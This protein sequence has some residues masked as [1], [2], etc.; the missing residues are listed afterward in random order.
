MKQGELPR[1]LKVKAWKCLGELR[2]GTTHVTQLF[3]T[4]C[5]PNWT[6]KAVELTRTF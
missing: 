1:D 5:I 4:L 6:D 3:K 2:R